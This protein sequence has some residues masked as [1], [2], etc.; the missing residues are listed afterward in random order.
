MKKTGGV[1]VAAGKAFEQGTVSPLMQIGSITI[2]KRIVL[3]FQKADISPIVMVTGYQALE[4]EQ[5]LADYGIIFLKNENYENSEKFD[6]AKIGLDFIKDKCEQVFFTSVTVPMYT[7]DTLRRLI[8]C[9]KALVTPSYQGKAGH[10]LLIDTTLLPTILAYAGESG[11]RGAI[12]SLGVEKKYLEVEDEGILLETEDIERLDQLL[13]NH[14]NHLLHP[15][16][17]LSIEKE[18]L[19]FNA[20]AKLLLLLIEETHSVKGACKHMALSYGKA[21]NMLNEMEEELGYCVVERRQGGSR[22]G[23]TSL[24]PEGAAFLEKYQKYEEDIRSYAIHHF[25]EIFEEFK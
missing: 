1:I 16:V 18:H 22:G 21:W 10:P 20:R 17:R 25:Y 15:F 12:Q 4:I 2:I 8:D 24:T 7:S 6:S 19:F 13:E 11:M 3:T 23:K 14:N 5:H 9:K